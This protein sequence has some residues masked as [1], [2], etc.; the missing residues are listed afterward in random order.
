MTENAKL[1]IKKKINELMELCQMYHAPLYTSVVFEN[2]ED[3]TEYYTQVFS[4]KAHGIE[5]ADD[6]IEKHIL[7]SNG[8]EAVPKREYNELDMDEILGQLPSEEG[9]EDL[10]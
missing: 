4:A 8:F 2:T 10:A 6:Q 1:D 7:I 9:K 5:L 3:T